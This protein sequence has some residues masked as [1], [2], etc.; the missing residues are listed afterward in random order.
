MGK[1]D[2][3]IEKEF[4]LIRKVKGVS[5]SRGHVYLSG[6]LVGKDVEV[7]FKRNLTELEQKQLEKNELTRKIKELREQ[8]L[9]R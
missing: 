2:K 1:K 3:K 8:R 4:I 5:Y 7:K 6:F 9:K